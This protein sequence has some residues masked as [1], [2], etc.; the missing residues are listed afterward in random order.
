MGRSRHGGC[1]AVG[2]SD[3]AVPGG[4]LAV[5]PNTLSSALCDSPV[6]FAARGS[7]PA[8]HVS[9]ENCRAPLQAPGTC[10]DLPA[11]R[12]VST[13]RT[14]RAGR[15][16]SAGLLA[17]TDR[18]PGA[19]LPH[20]PPW[21]G[22]GVLEDRGAAG[23]ATLCWPG[24]AGARGV[25]HAGQGSAALPA[26]SAA[27]G[28]WKHGWGAG[29][30]EGVRKRLWLLQGKVGPAAGPQGHSHLPL[31]CPFRVP[32]YQILI[33]MFIKAKSNRDRMHHFLGLWHFRND[34]SMF[35][36]LT[37]LGPHRVGPF[38]GDPMCV[39]R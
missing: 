15:L 3:V 2:T 10:L 17:M 14:L 38:P 22:Q 33:P 18:L 30:V 16:G 25:P 19:G 5:C 29:V 1:P 35:C 9:V 12:G 36:C 39:L 37:T 7:R 34:H 11:N 26:C 24:Q 21:E 28:K 6:S 8:C 32:I 13:S 4:C 27:W 20:P 31:H 23:V